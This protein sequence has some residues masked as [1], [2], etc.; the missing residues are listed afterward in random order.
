MPEDLCIVRC[1]CNGADGSSPC[2]LLSVER[3][4]RYSAERTVRDRIVFNC[5]EALQ[6]FCGEHGIKLAKLSGVMLTGLG[7]LEAPGLPGTIFAAADCGVAQLVVAG[8]PGLRRLHET[9]GSFVRRRFPRVHI[10]EVRGAGPGQS[11]SKAVGDGGDGGAGPAAPAE[12]LVYASASLEI[13]AALLRGAEAPPDAAP[14]LAG[15]PSRKRARSASASDR[16]EQDA[17]G[18]GEAWRGRWRPAGSNFEFY[19][20]TTNIT[21]GRKFIQKLML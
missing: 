21:N 6:R 9:M 4:H 11:G 5:S 19:I 15:E 16:E 13:S 20:A 10:E 12:Q 17:G 2:V 3:P 7:A 18:A 14:R 1:L 8:P